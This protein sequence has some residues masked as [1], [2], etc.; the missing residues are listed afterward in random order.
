M[1]YEV[2]L[3]TSSKPIDTQLSSASNRQLMIVS[4]S[5]GGLWA[6]VA[7]DVALCFWMRSVGQRRR[8]DQPKVTRLQQG[9]PEESPESVSR[10]CSINLGSGLALR[11]LC[12]GDDNC[13]QS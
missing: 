2:I 9:A 12:Q 1:A 10:L 11:L 4:T 7:A 5:C 13:P 3:L 8:A 6:C